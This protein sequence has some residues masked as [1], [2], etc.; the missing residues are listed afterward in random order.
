MQSAN[1]ERQT[2]FKF[3]WIALN[4][5]SF[6]S[7]YFLIWL[8]PSMRILLIRDVKRLLRLPQLETTRQPLKLD[9]AGEREAHFKMLQSAWI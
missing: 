3:A 8:L 2:V 5:Y 9:I 1:F 7:A 6:Y 4:C